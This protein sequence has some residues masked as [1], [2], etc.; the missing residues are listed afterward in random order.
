MVLMR[1]TGEA[2]VLCTERQLLERKRHLQW[3]EVEGDNQMHEAI[4]VHGM[5]Y[6]T[7]A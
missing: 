2:D 6:A 5:H 4:D 7:R 3:R 1:I